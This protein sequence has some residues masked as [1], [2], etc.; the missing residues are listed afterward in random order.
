MNSLARYDTPAYRSL[1]AFA[2]VA[3]VFFWMAYYSVSPVAPNALPV[4]HDDYSNYSLGAGPFEWSWIRPLSTGLVYFLSSLGPDYLIWSVRLFTIV[5]VFLAWKILGE[6]VSIRYYLPSVVLFAVAVLA[7]PIIA[8]YA[9]YTGMITHTMSGCLGLAA[10]YLLFV[11]SR[12]HGYGYLYLSAMLLILSALAKEDFILFYAFTLVYLLIK[13]DKA[14]APRVVI[15]GGALVAALVAVAGAKFIAASSFLGETNTQSPYF[16]DTSP[17]GVTQTVLRYLLGSS[18]P[19]MLHH[20]YIIL[21][22]FVIAVLGILLVS[23]RDRRLPRIVYPLGAGLAIMAPYSVLPNHVNAYYEIIWTPFI[24]GGA[25]VAVIEVSKHISLQRQ[26]VLALGTLALLAI[27][28][29]STD[30]PGRKSIAAWYDSVA[31][32]NR[33][34]FDQLTIN[35]TAINASPATCISGASSF[36]PWYMHGGKY[37]SYVLDLRTV[38]HVSMDPASPYYPGMQQGAA[39]SNGTVII[40]PTAPSADCLTITLGA[41]S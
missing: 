33:E 15:G 7:T 37:L 4:H 25:L 29:Y 27:T 24:L 1:A 39:A 8:E 11:D 23:V 38:W 5:Y 9:R 19:A 10:A 6:V 17:V 35:K 16:I 14:V 41:N 22:A 36:S 21:A 20:G 2:I 26:G 3:L 12:K 18:H 30:T 28:L 34:S 40:E 32:A 13:S 31:E